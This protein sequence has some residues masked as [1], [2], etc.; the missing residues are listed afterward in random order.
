[1]KDQ[2]A[3]TL[4]DVLAVVAI[5]GVCAVVALGVYAFIPQPPTTELPAYN[6]TQVGDLFSQPLS[7]LNVTE[8]QLLADYCMWSSGQTG[9]NDLKVR[10]SI[11]AAVYQNQIIINQ[12]HAWAEG[13]P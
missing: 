5:L 6:S 4:Q 12:L 8:L 11:K 1:M 10:W 2:R 13:W 3:F 7:S 9:Y